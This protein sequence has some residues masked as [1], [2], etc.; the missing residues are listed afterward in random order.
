MVRLRLR[1]RRRSNPEGRMS[2]MSHLRELRR[3]IVTILLIIAA[4]AVVGWI[5]Y[6]PILAILK[7]PYCSVPASHRFPP[8]SKDCELIFTAPLDGFTTRLKVS[9]LAG[10]VLTAPLWLY[11]IWAFVTPGLRKKER[12]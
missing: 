3:R 2:V 5:F 8:N 6:D 7:H 11:Q 1:R 9:V 12:K 10:A 4:G